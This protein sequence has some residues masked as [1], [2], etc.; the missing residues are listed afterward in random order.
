MI[1]RKPGPLFIIQNRLVST[2]R[3]SARGVGHVVFVFLNS[4]GGWLIRLWRAQSKLYPHCR[5]C[6]VTLP[7]HHTP[8]PA[9]ISDAHTEPYSG[10]FELSF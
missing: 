10:S 3:E 4:K 7:H 9:L 2:Q 8:F 5:T 6:T 1:T